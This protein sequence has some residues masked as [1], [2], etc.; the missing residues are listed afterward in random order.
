M[1]FLGA[2]KYRIETVA[3]DGPIFNLQPTPLSKLLGIPMMVCNKRNEWLG[4]E[5]MGFD[6]DSNHEGA[7]LSFD[8]DPTSDRFGEVIDKNW[9]I[10]LGN[11]IIARQDQ[12]PITPEQVESLVEFL[13]SK[14]LPAFC[15]FDIAATHGDLADGALTMAREEYVKKNICKARFLD[16]F[17]EFKQ[18]KI[19]EGGEAWA[20][21]VSFYGV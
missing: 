2:Q 6:P 9:D 14:I 19:G 5:D 15:T 20:S 13:L 3:K 10:A 17:Q 1:R 18:R 12:K 4:R 7:I 16:F 21:A 8:V 11:V